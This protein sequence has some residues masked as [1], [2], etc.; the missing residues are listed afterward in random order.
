MFMDTQY[1]KK[2]EKVTI[3]PYHVS[4]QPKETERFFFFNFYFKW[5]YNIYIHFH[6]TYAGLGVSVGGASDW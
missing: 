5:Y 6:H 2:I 1:Q 4:Q 3:F